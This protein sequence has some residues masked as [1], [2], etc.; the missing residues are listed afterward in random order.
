[1]NRPELLLD[2]AVVLP[3]PGE[4]RTFDAIAVGRGRVIA[5]GDVARAV[6]GP[7][8]RRLDLGGATVLPGFI[9]AHTH[10]PEFGLWL[11]YVDLGPADS[12]D[13]CLTRIAAERFTTAA[14]E[15][16]VGRSWDESR[17]P[18]GRMPT[19]HD[20]DRTVPDRPV[21]LMRVDMHMGVVNSA[22]LARLG[23]RETDF[24]EGHLIE[25]PFL[26]ACEALR[27]SRERQL[28]ALEQ[29]ITACWA[30]GV[31]TV[32]STLSPGDF[33]LL[34]RA[35]QQGGLGV[36]VT[37]YMRTGG[38]AA[39][40][41]LGLGSGFGDDRLRL[42]GVKVFL[43]GSV[44]ARSAAFGAPYADAPVHQGELLYAPEEFT[45]LMRRC[46]DAGLQPAV[47]SIGDRATATALAGFREAGLA[48]RVRP[49][50]EHAEFFAP[51]EIEQAAGLGAVASCQPNFVGEWGRPGGLYEQRLGRERAAAGNPYRW[52]V[53]AGLRLAFG[54]DHMPFGPRNGL[55]WAIHGPY[56]EQRLTPHEALHAYTTGAAFAGGEEASRG[57]LLPQ[58]DADLVVLDGDPRA[59]GADL[60]T[61]PVKLTMVAGRI[62]HDPA[63]L[64]HHHGTSPHG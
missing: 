39:L 63:Q 47:H 21:L 36:R 24:P 28:A 23:L 33:H 57:A 18:D 64:A 7:A 30:E 35:R 5:L 53:E 62:V 3:R 26:A 27:P 25:A 13:D 42:G 12:L 43:D 45:D 60:R 29:A 51:G 38:L 40:E 49:R 46:G 55:H 56:P 2:N 6:A 31:T 37:G 19:R 48:K 22:G 59:A 58:M 4:E 9:D 34:Q 17:W 20:L 41:T 52:M 44:G 15:W 50:L 8:T 11:S 16:L 1:M 61:M 54:S 14:E 10:L 32:H